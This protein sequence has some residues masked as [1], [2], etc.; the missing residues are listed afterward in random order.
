MDEL[1]K[2]GEAILK[3][4]LDGLVQLIEF[5]QAEGAIESIRDSDIRNIA[6]MRDGVEVGGK[7]YFGGSTT[8]GSSVAGVLNAAKNPIIG[9]EKVL[10]LLIDTKNTLDKSND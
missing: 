1:T 7:F 4:H 10:E 2:V 6:L 9:R 8:M 5:L 3:L